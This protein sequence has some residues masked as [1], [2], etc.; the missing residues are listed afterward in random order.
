MN[1]GHAG[2]GLNVPN[3]VQGNNNP[4]E[5]GLILEGSGM[6]TRICLSGP[7]AHSTTYTDTISGPPSPTMLNYHSAE[8]CILSVEYH[9]PST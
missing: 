9:I 1:Q 4:Y 7:Y 5:T 8:Y 3:V 2:R 6:R